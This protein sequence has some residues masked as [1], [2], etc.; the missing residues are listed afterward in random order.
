MILTRFIDELLFAVYYY[1]YD[2]D[3]GLGRPVGIEKDMVGGCVAASFPARHFAIFQF[4]PTKYRL[5]SMSAFANGLVG[6]GTVPL[7]R[8]TVQPVQKR[9]PQWAFLTTPDRLCR[10]T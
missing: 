10:F 8:K 4:F 2:K 7:T 3:M 1:C 5:L 9:K 6:S